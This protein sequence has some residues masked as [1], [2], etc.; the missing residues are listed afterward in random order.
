MTKDGA[1]ARA[2][3]IHGR[4]SRRKASSLRS[5]GWHTPSRSDEEDLVRVREASSRRQRLRAEDGLDAPPPLAPNTP[6][7]STG[8]R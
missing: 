8:Y 4:R 2:G 5:W 1:A 3:A 7:A 6:I